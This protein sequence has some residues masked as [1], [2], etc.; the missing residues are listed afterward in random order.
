MSKGGGM[1]G[2]G[3]SSQDFINIV[4]LGYINEFLNLKV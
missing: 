2:L 1:H 4:L 3:W